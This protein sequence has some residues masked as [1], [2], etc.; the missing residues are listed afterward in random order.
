MTVNE[1]RPILAKR[2]K[3]HLKRG[4]GG[5]LDAI[6]G[7]NQPLFLGPFWGQALI[8]W[9]QCHAWRCPS[10]GAIDGA[11][12]ISLDIALMAHHGPIYR[13][14]AARHGAI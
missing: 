3:N 7:T 10:I 8:I 11:I 6:L 5:R 14:I 13:A 9:G 2:A 4:I 12:F 1:Y